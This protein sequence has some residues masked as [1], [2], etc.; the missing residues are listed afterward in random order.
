MDKKDEQIEHKLLELESDVLKEQKLKAKDDLNAPPTQSGLTNVVENVDAKSDAY[1]F[2]GIGLILLG[3]FLLFQHVRVGTG[4]FAALGLGGG[5]FGLLMIPLLI[6]IG[7]IIYDNKS[8]VGYA[9]SS[10]TCLLIFVSI[11]SSL[12]MTFPSMHLLGLIMILAPL[13]VGG[14]FMLKGIGGVKTI[15]RKLREE[16]I[17]K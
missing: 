14:A 8:K 10:V 16:N 1:Y 17:L 5:G 12:V 4:F 7:W 2:S 9:I 6:G 3:L 15:T 13:A 11:L